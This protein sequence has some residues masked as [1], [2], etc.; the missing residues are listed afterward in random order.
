VHVAQ[1]H[2]QVRTERA[3]KREEGC[4][5]LGWVEVWHGVE[6]WPLSEVIEEAEDEQSVVHR[7]RAGH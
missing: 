1:P 5:K 7:G 6:L 2:E 3:L 4:Q